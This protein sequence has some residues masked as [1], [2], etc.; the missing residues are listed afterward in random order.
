MS[1]SRAIRRAQYFLPRDDGFIAAAVV[2]AIC[3]FDR[4]ARDSRDSLQ[5]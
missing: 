2:K 4:A 3:P 1:K 5:S